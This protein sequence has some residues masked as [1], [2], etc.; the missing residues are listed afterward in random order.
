MI[1]QT[2]WPAANWSIPQPISQLPSAASDL[3]ERAADPPRDPP[4][5]QDPGDCPLGLRDGRAVP[6]EIPRAEQAAE[7]EEDAAEICA[8]RDEPGAGEVRRVGEERRAGEKL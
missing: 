7:G 6:I 1:G 5:E 3:G 4:R 8:V 2:A